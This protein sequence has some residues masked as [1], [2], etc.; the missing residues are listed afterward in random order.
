M[1]IYSNVFFYKGKADVFGGSAAQG[2]Y[3]GP[4]MVFI[5]EIRDKLPYTQLWLNNLNRPYTH[6][7]VLDENNKTE[8][9]FSELRLLKTA[10]L[11]LAQRNIRSTL[12]VLKLVGDR[13]GLIKALAKHVVFLEASDT[14]HRVSKPASNLLIER[15]GEMVFGASVYIIGDGAPL[16]GSSSLVSD[17]RMTHVTNIYITKATRVRLLMRAHTAAWYNGTLVVAEP[18]SFVLSV[19]EIQD[20]GQLLLPHSRGMHCTI[21]LINMKY[22]AAIIADTHNVSVT[23]LVMEAGSRI[24]SSGKDRPTPNVGPALPSSCRGSGGSH[25]SQG[26]KGTYYVM[27]C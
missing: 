27:L 5:H 23:S 17:G 11:R 14:V 16:Q 1:A 15:D 8:Y 3:G 7:L 18:G 24:S 10:T 6:E 25:A 4:G 12:K 19:L 21:G 26:G 2:H 9:E 13:T 22:G 20:G